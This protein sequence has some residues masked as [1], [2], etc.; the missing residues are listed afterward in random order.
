MEINIY[1]LSQ[2]FD[3]ATQLEIECD[4]LK[5]SFSNVI[6]CFNP[7]RLFFSNNNGEEYFCINN[8]NT[9]IKDDNDYYIND[10]RYRYKISAK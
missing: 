2:C 8:I 6:V 10:M 3:S 5:L 7:N 9:I 1:E 4:Y